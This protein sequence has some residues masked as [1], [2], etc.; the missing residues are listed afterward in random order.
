LVAALLFPVLARAQLSEPNPY[1]IVGT[2]TKIDQRD[3]KVTVKSTNLGIE[4]EAKVPV[5]AAL[6]VDLEKVD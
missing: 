5:G 1:R 3:R 4:V 2:I 6:C